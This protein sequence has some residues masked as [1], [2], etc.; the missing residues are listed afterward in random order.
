[1]VIGVTDGLHAGRMTMMGE[2]RL[3]IATITI[4]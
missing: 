2:A 3:Q 1:M 4:F